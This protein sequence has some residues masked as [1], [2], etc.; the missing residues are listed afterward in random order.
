MNEFIAGLLMILLL[1][2]VVSWFISSRKQVEKPVKVMLFVLYFWILAFAQIGV[3][4]LGYFLL[5]KFN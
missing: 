4:A 2:A 5:D 3:V 1:S